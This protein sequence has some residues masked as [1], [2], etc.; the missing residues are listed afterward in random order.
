MISSN[1]SVQTSCSAR[2]QVHD[3]RGELFIK[4]MNGL[5]MT[6][7]EDKR[8]LCVWLLVRNFQCQFANGGAKIK[9]YFMEISFF[10]STL[11]SSEVLSKNAS[12]DSE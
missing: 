5:V 7:K 4:V 10:L 6:L 3:K 9:S 11:C 12:P 2:N 8:F 1:S